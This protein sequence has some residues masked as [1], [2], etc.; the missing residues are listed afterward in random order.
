MPIWPGSRSPE[1]DFPPINPKLVERLH[2]FFPPIEVTEK[3]TFDRIRW[4]GAQRSV[5]L[6]LEKMM[7]RQR[8]NLPLE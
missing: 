8:D 6:F 2:Q 4:R 7:E 5:I 1:E 3:D